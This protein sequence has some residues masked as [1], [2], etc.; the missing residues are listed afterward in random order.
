MAAFNKKW[1]HLFLKR[2]SQCVALAPALLLG[3]NSG[4]LARDFFDPA[5]MKSV[6]QSD[7]SSV[8]DL[9]I[10]SSKDA[11]S[12]GDYRVEVLLNND[13]Q[14]TA[15]IRFV[16]AKSAIPG[17]EN[18]TVLAPC[19]SLDRLASY[20]LR[21]NAFP[22]LKENA[23]GCANTEIIPD[24]AAEFNF[25]TQQLFVSIPQAALTSVAQGFIPESD[26]D[27]GINTLLAN[28]QFNASKD[29]ESENES[30][31]L[32]LQSGLNL[33]PWRLRNLGSWNKEAGNSGSWESVYLYAQRNIIPLKSTL[34]VGESSSLS[35]IFDSVPF[36]G[37]QLASDIDMLPESLRGYAPIVRGIAKTN[38][39]VVVKQNGYQIYQA[40]V[41]PGAF[42]IKDMYATGGNGD[43]Y[44]TVEEAD[45]SQQNFI[46]PFASLPL[47]LREGQVEYEI[48]SG[49][50]RPYDGDIDETP[51]TQ[52]TVTYGAFSNTTLY[53]GMQAAANYQALAFGVGHNLGYLGAV[54]ADVTQA[55]STLKDEDKTTGQSWRVRYGKNIL[56]TGTNVTIAGY[57]Y[58]TEGYRTL[59][60][61]LNTYSNSEGIST[62][63]LVRNRTNLT[64]NQSLGQGLGSISV[65]GL[66]EDYWDSKRRNS[67]LSLGYN[68]GW[69]RVNFY[70]GYSYSR[71][72][73]QDSNYTREKEDDHLFS[74]TVSV[75]I[76]EWLPNAYVSYQM[77][78]SNPGSTDQYVS[79]SGVAM[80]NN[81]LD[82][83]VQ[84]G[85]SNRES[86]SGGVYGTYRGSQGT[87]N[88][89][90]N[91]NQHSKQ[92]NYGASGGILLHANGLT[93]GQEMSDTAALIKAPGL[94]GVRLE[95]DPTIKTDYRGYAIVPYLSPYRRTSIT[96]DSTT[97]AGNMELPNATQK[98]VPT[99][100]AI[101]RA[102]FEGNIGHRAFLI[103][104]QPNGRYV[105]F[106]ATATP[107]AGK[108]T[109]A[110]IVGDNGM[111]YLSGLKEAGEI[112]AKWGPDS[113]QSCK[114]DYNLPATNEGVVQATVI[115][116]Q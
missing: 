106:G 52:A 87:V 34:V 98:V 65:T 19:L 30:Y 111:V 50:Y 94:S 57:R 108:G 81:N 33:G 88:G 114:A 2:Y 4:A 73:W 6:G 29:F 36:T 40:F 113:G 74:L 7:P 63:R 100:G 79:L 116:R 77:T 90:Y 85:Y 58:S 82:W 91:Y 8:P 53:T 102:D 22:Y 45:G 92:I 49:K 60:E 67:S 68:G 84:E 93:L 42:E 47:M 115:C 97:L 95:T 66:L 24:F 61:V 107:L 39:R 89:S 70:L 109:Q 75:P 12:P 99:R 13:Y 28:Y 23:D 11:Q 38:A 62:Y 25:N 20:G 32:N 112:L 41:A 46:V 55:W 51:F 78:N 76:G 37:V 16:E 104:K 101:V 21:L 64:V 83:S 80:E 17:E 9:S 103:L 56:D 3:L 44:V 15:T 1:N 43:L 86:T 18:N 71:Y 27:D 35:S 96:L 105:P 26:F 69:N 5:F 110:S 10:Y 31:G 14:E 48:T 54:S 72:T 59:S